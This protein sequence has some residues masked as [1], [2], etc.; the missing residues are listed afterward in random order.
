[1]KLENQL[2]GISDDVLLERLAT[3]VRRQ[4]ALTT[5]LLAHLGEVDRRRL[6]LREACS[7]MHRYCVERLG[8]SDGAAYKRIHAARAARRFPVLLTMIEQGQLH[9]KGI[10]LLAPHLT[11]A[12][13]REVLER[14]RHQP[15][16]A[17]EKLVAE[18]APRPDVSSRLRALPR[19]PSRPTSREALPSAMQSTALVQ[20]TIPGDAQ[21]PL[22][23]PASA[24]AKAPPAKKPVTPLAPRRYELRITLDESAHADL[25]QLQ[26]L[27]GHQI[28]DRDPAAIVSR[29]LA[30]LVDRTLARKSGVTDR[31]RSVPKSSAT[32][33][34]TAEPQGGADA[35]KRSRHI[36]ADVRRIV[37]RRDGGR[38]AFRDGRGRRCTSTSQ[39]EFHHLDNFARGADHAPD[40]L[41][42]RCR[43][44][45]LY[46]AKLDYG[47][48]FIEAVRSGRDRAREPSQTYELRRPVWRAEADAQA[49]SRETTHRPRS[50]SLPRGTSPIVDARDRRLPSA[51]L[52]FRFN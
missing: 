38:C 24:S 5:A 29:A 7:S 22:V 18:L 8:L 26:D 23:A 21:A 31:P 44:H 9:L 47:E 51:R 2:N 30:L 46:Q 43:A 37:W 48:A 17:I 20:S 15:V 49:A 52:C 34:A 12:N 32:A 35:A 36:P 3:L 10:T 13:C 14:A 6:Y 33:T 25:A 28:P 19:G 42:L 11:E 45:N 27:L 40:G 39:L 41:E 1:M 4:N 50:T 16:R